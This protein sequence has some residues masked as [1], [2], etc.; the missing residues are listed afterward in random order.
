M[1]EA[2]K[3]RT[4]GG[5]ASL[6]V[7]DT[8]SDVA[9]G[10]AKKTFA[11]RDGLPGAPIASSVAQFSSW[12]DMQGARIAMTSDGIGTKVEV[13]ERMQRFD[14]MGADLVAM[15]VDDLAA[16]G[17]E[18]VALTNT[19]DVDTLDTAVVDVLMRGLYEAANTAR[20]AVVGGEIA[21]LGNRIG[22]YGKGMHFNWCATALGQLRPGWEPI[23][24]RTIQVGDAIVAI[25]SSSMRS[26]GYS[27]ARRALQTVFGEM[28][29]T[30][31]HEGVSWG[32]RLLAPCQIYAPTIT[33]L[34]LA[35]LE[36]HGLAHIT[37]GGLPSKFG[38]I[39]KA[40]GLGA[41]LSDPFAPNSTFQGLIALSK[42]PLREAYQHWNMSNGF[43]IV[44][45]EARVSRC[46]DA[47]APF[48]AKR[49]GCIIET[50]EIRIAGERYALT[51]AK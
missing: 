26:N 48:R 12:L 7:Q 25:E 50:P 37:G 15:V 11:N 4:S 39:L 2:S 29:H 22:G 41:D 3:A 19:L 6:H 46:V 45:P 42:M 5:V 33:A 13:A 20:I 51:Q 32:D 44:L 18:P 31:M 8:A 10:W 47:C 14:T 35:G 16:N 24:G 23:D 38:R 30:E 43:V 49:I 1:V 40:C 27:A 36:M 34:R 17:V 9:Y 21:E 28:W